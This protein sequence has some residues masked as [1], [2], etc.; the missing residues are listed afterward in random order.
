MV[1]VCLSL[2]FDVGVVC[3]WVC[4]CLNCFSLYGITYFLCFLQISYHLS[5]GVF[6][7]AFCFRDGFLDRYCL[8]PDLS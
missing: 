7:L 8:N 4:V 3:L 2:L 5:V 1:S 6:L